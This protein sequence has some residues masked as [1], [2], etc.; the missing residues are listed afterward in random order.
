MHTHKVD[1]DYTNIPKQ[2]PNWPNRWKFWEYKQSNLKYVVTKSLNLFYKYIKRRIR[3]FLE[4]TPA[5]KYKRSKRIPYL[6]VFALGFLRRY[7]K[8]E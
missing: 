1:Q 2:S 6:V 7:S 3:S 5:F 8:K 4:K